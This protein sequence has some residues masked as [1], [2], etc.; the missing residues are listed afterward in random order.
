MKIKFDGNQ[1]YQL[2]AVSA[3]TGLFRGLPSTRGTPG[4][5]FGR[6]GGEFFSEFGV[7][8]Q[9]TIE[10]V[11]ILQN[12]RAIQRAN[13]IS[14]S[15]KLDGMNF[16]VEMET[17]TGKTYVYLRT[18]CELEREYGFKKF[19]IV[20]PSVAI[21]EG[22][23]KSIELTR[24]HFSEI[25]GDKTMEAWVYNSRHVARLRRFAQSN[26]TQIMIINIDS[27]NKASNNV[28]YQENERLAGRKPIEFIQATR[29]LLIIDEPQNMESDRSRES[30][31]N[32]GPLATFRYS[33]THRNLYNLVYRLNPVDAYNLELVKRIE[34]NS[35][36]E[37]EN[38]NRPYIRVKSIKASKSQI[39]A[40]LEIDVKQAAGYKRK[41][42]SVQNRS[43][44]FH[45]SGMRENYRDYIVNRI[46]AGRAL[47]SFRNGVML[48]EG[49]AHGGYTDSIMRQQI[50]QT[51]WQ[52]LEKEL[53]IS[54]S[55]FEGRRMKI[56]SLFFIDRVANYASETG[57]FRR[58]FIEA[59]EECAQQD[60]YGNLT[61]PP[62]DLVH[63]GYFAQDRGTPRDTTGA[64]K[65]DEEAYALIMRDKERLLSLD[66]PL[67]FIF[68][69]SALREGWDNPNV[70][71]I[72][73][74][75]ETHSE[76]K[77]RQEVGRGLRLPVTETGERCHDPKVNI[78]TV[79]VNESYED[80]VSK[81]QNEIVE[82]CG[83]EFEK[84]RIENARERRTAKLKKGWKLNQNFLELWE[85]IKHRTQYSVEYSSEDLVERSAAA[86]SRMEP[87]V[88]PI[89]QVK[90][91]GI[92]MNE[93]GLLAKFTGTSDADFEFGAFAIPDLVGYLQQK[94]ELTRVTLAE[95]LVKSN[96]LDT[97]S[98]NPQQYL[99]QAEKAIKRVLED[100]IINGIKYE[101]IEG[102]E[103]EMSLFEQ[104]EISSYIS[105]M[106]EV[107]N[108][109]YDSIE[110]DSDVEKRFAE[111]LDRRRDI[112]L[113]IKLPRWFK[114]ETPVGDYN[115]DWAIVKQPDGENA[116]LY[117]VRETKSTTDL[118][119][120]RP[121]EANKIRCGK[122]HF[123][124]LGVDFKHVTSPEEV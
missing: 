80:F 105:K 34:V 44:L 33:A 75:N 67:R 104:N 124:E 45:L 27:F 62:V 10:E 99:D 110:F 38:L 42:V 12:L 81:L 52:H 16:S 69:H 64:T 14:E 92:E 123:Q 116:K 26:D 43:D 84:G 55:H 115:P 58:W 50:R 48:N 13:G 121:D 17:G 54:N 111:G 102:S 95:I 24:D 36:V 15:S 87:V 20:V 2:N 106:V 11:Q 22:V 35:V 30:I 46:D 79:L 113:F 78:L 49:D 59:Y 85:K 32:L 66:E 96:T 37:G 68:S 9:L 8:N 86:L 82:E 112:K 23:L 28:I 100:I 61:L 122:A 118:H 41:V 5:P 65:A 19:I 71:Q 93:E 89:I 98:A 109:I 119:K 108:S 83:V 29:P 56:L 74:L 72:C 107:E 73:T 63:S 6:G 88:S 97:V 4:I 94:T 70:F 53:N 57:K 90:T 1:E 76:M 60:L 39:R 25:Y 51:V 91:A 3:V 47:I 117:L 18:I 77:K 21:R 7:G 40:K 120:L 103:Y 31:E 101:R 114:V